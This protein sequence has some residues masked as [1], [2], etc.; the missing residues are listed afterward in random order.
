VQSRLLGAEDVTMVYRRGPA[1]MSASDHEQQWA[2]K[3][4]VR[5]KHWAAPQRTLVTDGRLTGVRFAR[6]AMQDG[7]LVLTDELF[8]IEADVV[9]SA[10]GQTFEAQPL[11][12]ALT[13]KDGRIA[14]DAAGRTSHRNV[15]AGGDCRHGGRDLTVEA[16]EQGKRAALD[17]DRSLRA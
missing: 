3:N 4:G 16:V 12:L 6:T 5:I 17:I 2:Q 15:W 7:R 8:D 11:G 14:T 1:A 9:L 13:L 10:I